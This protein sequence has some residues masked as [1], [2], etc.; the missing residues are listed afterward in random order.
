MFAP[1]QFSLSRI[2]LGLAC[3]LTTPHFTF[4]AEPST[5]A[6]S[7]AAVASAPAKYTVREGDTLDKVIRM[8]MG[9]SPL[10]IE[11]LREAVI[12]QNPQ[13]FAKGSN[14]YLLANAVLTLPNHS[15]LVQKQLAAVLPPAE[16]ATPAASN[17]HYT[18]DR[19]KSWVRYP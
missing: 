7:P 17:S 9:N 3:V 13:A 15:E 19:R 14:K 12:Q 1:S 18:E 11:I 10:R 8:H 2:G 4:A 6:V 16:P 5:A